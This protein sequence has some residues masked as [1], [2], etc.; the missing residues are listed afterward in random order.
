[1]AYQ[2][3]AHS[4]R[5]QSIRGLFAQCTHLTIKLYKYVIGL[6]MPLMLGCSLTFSIDVLQ[7]PNLVT[8]SLNNLC[9]VYVHIIQKHKY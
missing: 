2:M 5:L 3:C 1:M 4:N 7:V 6:A 9:Y 8:V